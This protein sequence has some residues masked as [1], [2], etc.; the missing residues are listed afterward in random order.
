MID[1][2]TGETIQQASGELGLAEQMAGSQ[3]DRLVETAKRYPRS[4]ARFLRNATELVTANETV[5]ASCSYALPRGGKTLTGPSVRFAEIIASTWGNLWAQVTPIA[6]DRRFV[7]VRAVAWDVEANLCLAFDVR[8]RITDKKGNTF[9]DDMIGVTIAAASSVAY[10]NAVLRVVPESVTRPVLEA[11]RDV[12]RGDVTTLQ[13]RRDK[14]FVT[15][16]TM[17][18]DQRR[19]LHA[20]GVEDAVQIG[21]D[22]FEVLR[23]ALQAI[24]FDGMNIDTVFPPIDAAGNEIVT[25]GTRTDAIRDRVAQRT[26]ATATDKETPKPKKPDPTD[27]PSASEQS[28]ADFLKSLE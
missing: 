23:G 4:M 13:A 25:G 19:I 10:R 6:E 27:S 22:E 16:A 18:V 12:V 3:I 28:G 5:A 1:E 2:H 17:G 24:K 8:R 26:A 9:N 7:T 21:L 20:L 14:M 11:A 15:F